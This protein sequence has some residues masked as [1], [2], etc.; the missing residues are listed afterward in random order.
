MAKNSPSSHFSSEQLQATAEQALSIVAAIGA[1]E[2]ADLIDAWITAGNV[3]AVARIAQQD[4]APSA[5]R[6]AA[7]RGINVLKSRGVAI[8]EKSTTARPFARPQERQIE[9][10]FIPFEAGVQGSVVTLFTRTVGRDCQF[11]DIFFNDAVGITRAGGGTL[12]YSKLQEWEAER[13]RNRGYDAITVPVEWAR[14]RIAQARQQN[15]RSGLLLPLELDRYKQLLEPVPTSNPGHPAASL[16]LETIVDSA[17]VEKSLQLHMEPEF[18]S[19]LLPQAIMQEML[20]EV[21][22]RISL[23][24]RQAEQSE[25]EA[26]IDEEKRAATDRFFQENIRQQL[27]DQM[28]DVLLSIYHRLGKERALDLL[29]TR[30]AILTAGLITQPPREI[31]FLVGFFEKTLAMMVS[32]SNGQLS[33]PLPAPTT[34]AGPVLSQEQLAAVEAA[35]QNP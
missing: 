31:P 33:I 1:D 29:A 14:W 17:R 23:L 19:F 13:R 28:N 35:R 12:S 2:Q 16:G 8:P 9:A 10:R 22:K 7:R 21:G 26:F 3:A 30:E 20:G 18:R 24:G 25:V 4:N 32:E 5:A 11:V 27:A 34:N 15:Q 6:K